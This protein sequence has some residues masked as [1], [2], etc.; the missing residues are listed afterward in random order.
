[1]GGGGA[2][3]HGKTKCRFG[4]RDPHARGTDLSVQANLSHG[5]SPRIINFCLF[6]PLYKKTHTISQNITEYN[7]ISRN[8][9]FYGK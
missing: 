9:E 2:K 1:M 4:I 5:C 7:R 6:Q 3:S 8:S